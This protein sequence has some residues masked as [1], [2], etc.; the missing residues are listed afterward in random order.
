[1]P[2]RNGRAFAAAHP[3][4]AA[5]VLGTTRTTAPDVAAFVN[6]TMIR[7]FDFND[8]YVGKEVGHPGDGIAACLAV[9]ESQRAFGEDLVLAIVLAYEIQCGFQEAA[10]LH[11]RG[12]D[13]VNYVLLSLVV[14]A[15]RLMG[16]SQQRLIEADQHSGERPHRDAPGPSPSG[17]AAQ[18]P[19]R[20]GTRSSP[21]SSPDT[22]S[23]D[24][25]PSSR[26]SWGS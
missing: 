26:A 8:G 16:L 11:P 23:P 2:S 12:W 4:T 19:T 13:H 10:A 14:A 3:S 24:R 5:T 20:C 6:G 9:A 15:G 18:H 25:R 17:R 21:R 1:M 7:H 22:A